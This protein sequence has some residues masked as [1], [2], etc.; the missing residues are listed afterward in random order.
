MESKK[1]LKANTAI[2]CLSPNFGGMELDAIKLA[3]KLSFYNNTSLIVKEKSFIAIQYAN[4]LENNNINLETIKFRTK[5]SL[6]IIFRTRQII[7]KYDIKNVIFFGASELKSLYFAFLGMD[8]NL[9]IRHGTTKTRPKKDMFH[10]LFYSKVNY[11]VA[12]SEHIMTNVK[13]IIPFGKETKETLIYP[14]VKVSMSEILENNKSLDIH[15]LHTGRITEG[16]GQIDAINA[17][18]ILSD[19][20][21]Q[22]TL[23]IVGGYENEYEKQKFLS[24]IDGVTYKQNI[25]VI[26]FSNDITSFLSSSNIFIFPSYGE[27]FGNSFVEALGAGLICICYENTTFI[28][29]KKLGFYIHIVENK[30]LEQLKERLLQIVQNIENEHKKSNDNIQLV[31]NLFSEKR[32]ISQYMEILK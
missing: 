12:I 28:E 8:I 5:L 1:K 7:K 17:C 32:E 13:N 29:F 19:K 2:I 22:F 11:H 18:S 3:N 27:G 24:F 14:S 23:K 26:G 30:N 31:K 4:H 6:S 21:I 20:N 9:I 15:L 25:N 16:K 10:K